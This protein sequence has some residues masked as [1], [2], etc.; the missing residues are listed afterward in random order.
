MFYDDVA[1]PIHDGYPLILARKGAGGGGLVVK[2]AF[3][4]HGAASDLGPLSASPEGHHLAGSAATALAEFDTPDVVGEEEAGITGIQRIEYRDAAVDAVR[5]RLCRI[6]HVSDGDV[7]PRWDVLAVVRAFD[8][9]HVGLDHSVHIPHVPGVN[10]EEGVTTCSE[11]FLL[12]RLA[13]VAL[14][15]AE[16]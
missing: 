8:C 5:Q 11:F 4:A 13:R 9:E 1:E 3:D 16:R 2:I 10:A 15:P 7:A 12:N 14:P 6:V